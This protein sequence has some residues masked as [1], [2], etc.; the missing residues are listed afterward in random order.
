MSYMGRVAREPFAKRGWTVHPLAGCALALLLVAT[1]CSEGVASDSADQRASRRLT[2]HDANPDEPLDGGE[3]ARLR[4]ALRLLAG[5]ANASSNTLRGELAH[6]T[7]ARINDGDVTIGTVEGARGP[8]RW[9]MCKDLAHAACDGS[10]TEDG[11]WYGDDSLSEALAGDLDGYMWGNRLYFAFADELT[12]ELLAATLVH[13]VN[14]ILNRSECSYY[15]DIEQ[16]VV[17]DTAAYVEEYRA[18]FSECLYLDE[19][20]SSE[21]CDVSAATHVADYG[22]APD[23]GSITPEATTRGIADALGDPRAPLGRL[24]PV[25]EHWP[26]AFDACE[27]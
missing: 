26:H 8:D 12:D 24:L 21:T 23:I 13:E 1:G 5:A 15:L 20:A 17:D 18:F 16:H 25:E 19:H 9:H 6:H 4:D 10:I 11:A 2:F 27:P 22:F 3:R 7:L 14:H